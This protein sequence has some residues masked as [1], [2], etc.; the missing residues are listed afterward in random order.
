MSFDRPPP[1]IKHKMSVV[2]C[3]EGMFDAI[4]KL[5]HCISMEMGALRVIVYNSEKTGKKDSNFERPANVGERI[6]YQTTYRCDRQDHWGAESC[7]K[8]STIQKL[9]QVDSCNMVAFVTFQ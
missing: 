5:I 3:Q 7:N 4:A 8:C 1:D 9:R 2:R 6:K